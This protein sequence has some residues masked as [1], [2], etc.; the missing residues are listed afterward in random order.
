MPERWTQPSSTQLSSIQPN[1]IRCCC[2][3]FS[4]NINSWYLNLVC[5]WYHHET[6]THAQ[7]LTV[8]LFFS[9]SHCVDC[10]AAAAATVLAVWWFTSFQWLY[11]WIDGI[12]SI[13]TQTH[14]YRKYLDGCLWCTYLCAWP[15]FSITQIF[16][17]S[18]VCYFR[19]LLAHHS[20]TVSNVNMFVRIGIPST[21]YTI[22][23]FIQQLTHSQ[24]APSFRCIPR[25]RNRQ[26]HLS[27]RLL[28]SNVVYSWKYSY[29]K[30]FCWIPCIV[31]HMLY[32][33]DAQQCLVCCAIVHVTC[34]TSQILYEVRR[35]RV[36][37]SS[38]VMNEC[39]VFFGCYWKRKGFSFHQANSIRNTEIHVSFRQPWQTRVNSTMNA[40][41]MGHI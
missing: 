29:S 23:P 9:M 22:S 21:A 27:E 35:E 3:L 6:I 2:M 15:N 4:P 38:A 14:A 12:S 37:E 28:E 7:S 26:K 32:V 10:D 34:K 24:R 41:Q 17:P 18:R 30:V 19:T 40:N 33:F 31:V 1:P 36:W 5:K 16:T 20:K 11:E 39:R 25:T 13:I 8:Y